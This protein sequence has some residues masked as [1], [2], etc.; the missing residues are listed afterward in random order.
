MKQGTSSAVGIATNEAPGSGMSNE[1]F[2]LA[3]AFAKALKDHELTDVSN[4]LERWMDVQ[5]AMY[6][7]NRANAKQAAERRAEEVS[8]SYS[9]NIKHGMAYRVYVSMSK[10]A[11]LACTATALQICWKI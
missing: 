4:R 3:G 11:R 6:G 10:S 2:D 8:T 1:Y 5:P 7:G 9:L